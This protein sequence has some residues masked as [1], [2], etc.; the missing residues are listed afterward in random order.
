MTARLAL[1]PPTRRTLRVLPD[2]SPPEPAGATTGA[3]LRP[4][5]VRPD[6]ARAA[7]GGENPA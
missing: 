7:G 2:H 3:R 4:R 1:V 6:L 5:S